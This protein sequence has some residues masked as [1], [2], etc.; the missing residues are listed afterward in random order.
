M[1]PP[2]VEA[3]KLKLTHCTRGFLSGL[4]EETSSVLSSE[5]SFCLNGIFIPKHFDEGEQWEREN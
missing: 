4:A 3:R 1:P 5:S 2:L